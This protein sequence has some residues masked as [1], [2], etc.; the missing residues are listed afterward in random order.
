[1]VALNTR[2]YGSPE[3]PTLLLIHGL[4]GS[5]RN[6]SAVA[7]KLSN[8]FH[9]ISVDLRN[10]GHSPHDEKMTMIEMAN[11]LLELDIYTSP[12]YAAGH[13]LG[14]KVLLKAYELDPT[15]FKKLAIIDIAPRNYPPH[16]LNE[17]DEMI[18]IPVDKL[19]SKKEAVDY[20]SSDWTLSSF[21]LTNLIDKNKGLT[22]QANITVIR[23]HLYQLSSAPNCNCLGRIK[24]PTLFIKG[25]KSDFITEADRE[26]INRNFTNAHIKTILD[27]G[28]S[29]HME[30]SKSTTELLR[31][32]F[33]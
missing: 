14:G 27:C 12:I 8:N 28:H 25:E 30:D 31:N 19:Q 16:F 5:L 17:L 2:N 4:L 6:W 20:L 9:V 23:K 7:R 11:D 29:P 1:M 26:L 13:S 10:H 22:W 3:S 24:I 33:C 32:F 21:L 15:K 18:A